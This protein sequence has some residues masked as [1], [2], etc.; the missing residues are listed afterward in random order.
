LKDIRNER[1]PQW[2]LASYQ[3]CVLWTSGMLNAIGEPSNY[4][5]L[6]F[7]HDGINAKNFGLPDYYHCYCQV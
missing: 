1:A 7:I 3:T 5:A 6:A 4:E 2:S